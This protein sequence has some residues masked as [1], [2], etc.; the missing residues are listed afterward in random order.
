MISQNKSPREFNVYDVRTL[1]YIVDN[2]YLGN[3][4]SALQWTDHKW[5]LGMIVLQAFIIITTVASF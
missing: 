4:N 2:I 3:V 5:Q 1:S